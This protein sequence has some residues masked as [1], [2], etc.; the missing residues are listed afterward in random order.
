[1][2]ARLRRRDLAHLREHACQ[3][4]DIAA[5]PAR[6]QCQFGM[7]DPPVLHGVDLALAEAEG[8]DEKVD[9]RRRIGIVEHGNDALHAGRGILN[10]ILHRAL[11]H[12]FRQEG[13]HALP[14][15]LVG[16]LVAGVAG[17][18]LH[19][20]P[21]DAPGAVQRIQR[22]PQV[23]VLDRLARRRQ[24]AAGLPFGDP[25]RDAVL[26]V[27]AVGMERRRAALRHRLQRLDGGLQ[28]HAV[29]GRLR[30]A[31]AAGLLLRPAP[32]QH[33]PAARPRITAARAVGIEFGPRLGPAAG[34]RFR[35]PVGPSS[36]SRVTPTPVRR[37]V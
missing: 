22:L 20:A 33:A 9:G 27:A 16:P 18:A 23:A 8:A 17:M 37:A 2:P 31:A 25:A 7:A 15:Q 28:F 13:R 5:R 10:R 6:A 34:H 14:G 4:H 1:M 26:D 19:P 11:P 3:H 35:H 21:V 32:D 30:G 29:V 36:L 24:P 12:V